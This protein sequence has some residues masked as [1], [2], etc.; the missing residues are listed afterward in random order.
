[1]ETAGPFLRKIR[2]GRFDL[3]LDLQRHLKSG[4]ISRWSGAPHR[5]GFH[6]LDCKEF[7][8]VFNNH[9]IPAGENGISKFNHYLKF[10]EYLS[11]AR[12]G[13]VEAFVNEG[14]SRL[15]LIAVWQ[16]YAALLPRFLSAVDGRVKDGS[17]RKYRLAQTLYGSVM[18]LALFCLAANKTRSWQGK[19]RSL[20]VKARPTW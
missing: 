18:V 5:L 3:V 15:V 19:S 14:G 11:G 13:G 6:R 7:N 2:T 9:H 10:A 16:T 1:M 4:I 17:R 12:A 8:W 20:A